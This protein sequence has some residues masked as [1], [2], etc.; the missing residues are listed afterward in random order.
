VSEAVPDE[1]V[2]LAA[3][4][5]DALTWLTANAPEFVQAEGV[6]SMF[7]GAT[8][9]E[10]DEVMER[11]RAWEAR[12]ARDGWAGLNIPER[13]GG[14]GLGPT[15]SEVFADLETR[16]GL[17]LEP[18]AVTRG[19]VM[20]TI[21]SMGSQDQQLTYVPRMLDGSDLWCQMFSE[22]STGSD[23]ASVATRGSRSGDKWVIDGQKVWTSHGH[24]AD[25]GY[26]LA[27]TEPDAPRYEALTAFIVDMHAP[28]VT[29]RPIR[30]LT[31]A[32]GFCEVYFDGVEVGPEAVIGEPGQGWA[33]AVATLMH[34]RLATTV[35]VIP[36][37]PFLDLIEELPLSPV[38][39]EAAARVYGQFHALRRLRKELLGT[40]A[41]GG[42]PGPEG[43]ASKIMIGR[44]QLELGRLTGEALART[45]RTDSRWSDLS[46][47]AL[48]FKIGGGTD[49]ILLDVI[50]ER[51]LGLPRDSRAGAAS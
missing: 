20:P 6:V 39:H 36:W 46:L 35:G 22:P 9:A 31:G 45:G 19:T 30:Q 48:G 21:A 43:S 49:E 28:G 3:F 7:H 44:L 12:K 51:V 27:R 10:E 15:A 32:S 29:T 38:E 41:A 17:E 16:W 14:R 23:L 5:R 4:E 8:P 34:E 2:D 26:L 11:A 40:L 33:V 1:P 13:L 24:R 42:R 18:F 25:Y 47:G 50:A 37:F